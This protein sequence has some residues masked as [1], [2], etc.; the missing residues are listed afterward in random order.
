MRGS[1]TTQRRLRQTSTPQ[2]AATT[3]RK[4]PAPPWHSGA[5][6]NSG[7]A[8]ERPAAVVQRQFNNVRSNTQALQPTGEAQSQVVQSPRSD[9]RADFFLGATMVAKGSIRAVV[10]TGLKARIVRH[11]SETALAVRTTI[12]AVLTMTMTMA[13]IPAGSTITCNASPT[14]I[15]SR[16][17]QLHESWSRR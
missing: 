5:V 12:T 11:A 1:A 14:S 13:M 9:R 3:T 15:R 4:P 17:K 2:C 16:R 8:T 10:Q 6:D 7:H